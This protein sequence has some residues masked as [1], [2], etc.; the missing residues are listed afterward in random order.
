MKVHMENTEKKEKL[1][2]K[3]EEDTKEIKVTLVQE[4]KREK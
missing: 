4:V 3:E 1:V 2:I